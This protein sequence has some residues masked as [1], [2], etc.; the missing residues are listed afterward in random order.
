MFPAISW[1]CISPVFSP[2]G[3][4][5]VAGVSLVAGGGVP[6]EDAGALLIELGLL[7]ADSPAALPLGML[8]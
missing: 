7:A 6:A 5:E 3:G 4:A 1:C 2:L 8:D